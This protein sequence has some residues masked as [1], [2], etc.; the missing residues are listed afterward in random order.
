MLYDLHPGKVLAFKG[1]YGLLVSQQDV[2][3]PVRV[4]ISRVGGGIARARD[5]DGDVADRK[6]E[7]IDYRNLLPPPP[8]DSSC[9]KGKSSREGQDSLPLICCSRKA[10]PL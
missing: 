3:V 9:L 8:R 4:A 7:L 2:Q 6:T 1:V 10:Y 5:R